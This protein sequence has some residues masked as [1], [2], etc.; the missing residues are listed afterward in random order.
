M[1]AS[2]LPIHE[3][4]P[5]LDRGF[6]FLILYHALCFWP[7]RHRVAVVYHDCG[8]EGR[9]DTARLLQVLLPDGGY[10]VQMVEA[11]FDE[12]GSNRGSAV[13]CVA[14]YIYEKEKCAALDEEWLK[15]LVANNL[16]YFRM[17]SCAHG[18][19]PFELLDKDCRVE[20]EKTLIGL[21]KT[22][23]SYGCA[24]SVEP[25]KYIHIMPI[26]SRVGGSYSFC[27]NTCLQAVASW[28][29]ESN[30]HGDIA[31]FFES[32]HRSQSEANGIMDR[33]FQIPEMRK[34]YRYSSHTFADKRKV[35]AL[36]SSDLLAWQWHTDQKRRMRGSTI[37]RLRL[38]SPYERAT[39][40]ALRFTF[41]RGADAY[42][43]F[44]DSAV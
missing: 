6:F 14:G 43:G 31:Y 16:P 13:L 2:V 19:A 30:Y 35:M 21:I 11:Y 29:D 15:V 12:S 24:V 22:F 26:D 39:A 32:G 25:S 1:G 42:V 41:R 7:L 37:S 9:V 36:Q 8:G 5:I 28:A 27:V 17:S 34:R 44:D 33:I 18:T 4:A 40:A 38:P 3:A 20:I 23:A 10:A